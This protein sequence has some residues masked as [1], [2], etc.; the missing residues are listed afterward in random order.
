MDRLIERC[1]MLD[2]HKSQI[3]ACVRVPDDGGGRRQEI[4]EFAATTAGLLTLADWLR[5]WAVT[6]VGMEATGVYW[7]PV[8][9][10]LED[11]FE[12][13]LYNAAHLRHA[14]GQI[15]EFRTNR[16]LMG[17]TAT[18]SA[19]QSSTSSERRQQCSRSMSGW[20]RKARGLTLAGPTANHAL[21]TRHGLGPPRCSSTPCRCRRPRPRSS[22][23]S[24]G[25]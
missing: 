19:G 17:I 7:R 12:C 1:S 24:A 10:L 25:R 16:L 14:P 11:E 3:T 2:V 18:C 15:G 5:R 4:R 23:A 8:F 22:R 21:P 9:Y 6:V 20:G 13:R